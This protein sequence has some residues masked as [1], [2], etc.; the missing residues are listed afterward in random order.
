MES[1]PHLSFCSVPEISNDAQ[2]S[3]M[4]PF[5]ETLLGCQDSPLIA[6]N[7]LQAV[8]LEISFAS[9]RA[10]ARQ[11]IFNSLRLCR[12]RERPSS[13]IGQ[14]LRYEVIMGDRGHGRHHPEL[15]FFS[16]CKQI[17]ALLF[18]PRTTLWD[19]L[20]YSRAVKPTNRVRVVLSGTRC[21]SLPAAPKVQIE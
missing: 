14:H 21:S 8:I 2:G 5:H 16:D 10:Y 19:P 15:V 13:D 7:M 4:I 18:L 20:G 11:Q 3:L 12:R 9:V 1:R 6:Q 17:F